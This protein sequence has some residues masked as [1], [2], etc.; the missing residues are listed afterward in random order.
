M[1]VALCVL[2]QGM[3]WN[4]HSHVQFQASLVVIIAVALLYSAAG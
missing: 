2:E 3:F 1:T 4:F